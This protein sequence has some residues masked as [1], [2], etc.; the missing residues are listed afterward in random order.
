MKVL[1]FSIGLVATLSAQS[2]T[3]APNGYRFPT[4]VDYSGYWKEN[5]A[6]VPEPFVVRGD[7]NGDGVADEVWLLPASSA[8]G[9]GLFVALGSPNGSRR[10]ARLE[11]DRK[12]DVHSLGVTLVEPGQ[13]KTACGKGYWACKRDEPELLDL[14]SAAFAFF[15]FESASSIFWWDQ[16]SNSFKRTW[17]S[18]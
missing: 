16:R 8:S 14:K 3:R 17:I 4:E 6:T 2:V 1:L 11:Q 13:Y 9:W 12:S 15:Q 5:R 18:D 7:F 10:W